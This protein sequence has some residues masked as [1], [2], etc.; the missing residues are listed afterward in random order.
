MYPFC[1]QMQAPFDSVK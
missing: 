1:E